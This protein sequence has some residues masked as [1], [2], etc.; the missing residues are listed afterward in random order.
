M[1]PSA[2]EADVDKVIHAA[3]SNPALRAISL[4][5]FKDLTHPAK[6]GILN[7]LKQAGEGLVVASDTTKPYASSWLTRPEYQYNYALGT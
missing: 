2:V 6:K 3:L 1:M 4:I 5:H 7:L